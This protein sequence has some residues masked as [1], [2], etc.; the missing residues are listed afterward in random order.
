MKVYVGG[1]NA[2]VIGS[3]L[4][5]LR[6]GKMITIAEFQGLMGSGGLRWSAQPGMS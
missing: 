6:S 1:T 3:Q 2:R 5:L 4:A